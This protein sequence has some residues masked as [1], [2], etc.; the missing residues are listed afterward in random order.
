[1]TRQTERMALAAAAYLIFS[2]CIQPEPTAPMRPMFG[3]GGPLR[4]GSA[5]AV[6]G[7]GVHLPAPARLSVE[8]RRRMSCF[9]SSYASRRAA[10]PV[11]FVFA[12]LC[13]PHALPLRV[14]ESMSSRGFCSVEDAERWSSAAAFLTPYFLSPI[15]SVL[16]R[17]RYLG[18]M[19]MLRLE[20]GREAGRGEDLTGSMLP[21]YGEDAHLQPT[22]VPP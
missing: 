5:G 19:L 18:E 9:R 14:L 22:H 21:T 7:F 3:S 2:P 12:A 13:C 17:R 8:H 11:R 1:M 15:R 4:L 6:P 16:M 20:G 10:S